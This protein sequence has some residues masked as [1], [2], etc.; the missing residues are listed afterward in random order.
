MRVLLVR[1]PHHNPVLAGYLANEPLP[2]ETVAG[3]APDHEVRLL[4]MQFDPSLQATL[5]SF[6]PDV[7][8]TGGCT[9]D[10]PAI[11]KLLAE[12]K[13]ACPSCLTVVG[14]H[15]ATVAPGD[16]NQAAIDAVV[17]GM[18]ELTFAEL[19]R[20]VERRGDLA[21]VAGLALPAEGGLRH[22]AERPPPASLDELPEPR[23]DLT[24][25]YRRHYRAFGRP[26]GV[27]NT[28]KGCPFRCRFCAIVTEMKGRY[29]TKSPD[30][31]V[32]ELAVIPQRYV[33]FADGNT[34][35]SARRM[36]LLHD[37]IRSAGLRKRLMIDA[38]SD[39]VA[40][41]PELIA[42]W[43]A[44]GLEL[45]ALGLESIRPAQL[46]AMGKGS[47]VEENA[48]AIEIL[49]DNDIR[50]VG[51]FMVDQDFS[52]EDFDR[53]LDFVLEQRIQLPSFLITT[54]FPGTPL[55]EEQASRLVTDDHTRFDCFHSVLPTALPL[56]TFYRRFFELY[57][58]AYGYRRM[59]TA[60][61][62]RVSRRRRSS[63]LP[64]PVLAVIRLFLAM[65]RRKLLRSLGLDEP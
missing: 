37:A 35:G 9:A 39:T 55:H 38:R 47:T 51:Q 1:P 21:Q 59:T 15:H 33:R 16:F 58:G 26:V 61:R 17:L 18:G 48:R 62:D 7:V 20:T 10:V 57:E 45:V 64:L 11:R 14:G 12:A 63:D 53:L 60:A 41:H 23:R 24:A 25:A 27:I 22:T 8:G 52:E 65:N 28:A 49:H 46:A 40:R 36:T 34:F 56:S 13:R 32:S 29:L 3:A 43:R 42:R 4:D 6:Q 30:R 44:I 54:P 19:L 5:E 2:L 31:V 50:I